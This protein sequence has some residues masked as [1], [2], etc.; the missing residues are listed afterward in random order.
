MI[1]FNNIYGHKKQIERLL[2]AKK[3]QRLPHALLFAGPDGIGKKKIALALAQS[4]LCPVANKADE[5][6]PRTKKSPVVSLTSFATLSAP[7]GQHSWPSACGKC[8]DCLSVENHKNFHLMFI[9][10]EGL[11]IKVDSIREVGRFTSLQ[12][13]APARVI[14]MD[15]AHQMNLSSANSFLKIL[16]EPPDGVYFFL[17]SSSMS[18]L[19]VTIRSRTQIVRFAPLSLED[20][21]LALQKIQADEN[22]DQDKC[23]EKPKRGHKDQKQKNISMV[24]FDKKEDQWLMEMSQGR[25]SHIEKWRGHKVLVQQALELLGQMNPEKPSCSLEELTDLVRDRQKALLVCS[26]WQRV[27]R[28]ARI[29]KVTDNSHRGQRQ[30]EQAGFKTVTNRSS[31]MALSKDKDLLNFLDRISP[32]LLD[33]FFEKAIQM[34]QDLKG[35][36]DSRLLFDNFLFFSRSQIQNLDR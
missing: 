12:S 11:Y 21:G 10:P 32:S 16:E 22:Q 15:S 1:L 6:I 18:A 20:T 30:N 19:P 27:I 31:V 17:I 33:L 25:L 26:C 36:V 34:E 13:L 4:L 3:N 5:K 35:H 14:L 2:M 9:Q 7:D 8:S 28:E 23:F 24:E 29:R